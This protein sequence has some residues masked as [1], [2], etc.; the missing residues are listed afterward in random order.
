L[1]NNRQNK[2]NS[3]KSFSVSSLD[4]FVGKTARVSWL[5][6]VWLIAVISG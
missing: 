3:R 6:W 5:A 4:K 2:G 1:N